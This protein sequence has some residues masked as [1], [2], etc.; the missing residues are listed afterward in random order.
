MLN[1]PT[2]DDALTAMNKYGYREMDPDDFGLLMG[3]SFFTNMAILEARGDLGTIAPKL[4]KSFYITASLTNGFDICLFRGVYDVTAP[5]TDLTNV[6]VVD[7]ATGNITYKGV[8]YIPT[9]SS[10]T[11]AVWQTTDPTPVK[12]AIQFSSALSSLGTFV[13]LFNGTV[14]NATFLGTKLASPP[15]FNVKV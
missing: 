7:P 15:L 13:V 1:D 4:A 3:F 8:T 6:L 11:N 5:N 9:L 12:Y 2:G 10:N 14:D